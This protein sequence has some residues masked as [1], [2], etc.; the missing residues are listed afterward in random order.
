M[1][2]LLGR[3]LTPPTVSDPSQARVVQQLYYV[4]LLGVPIAFT[5]LIMDEE[6]RAGVARWNDLI[7]GFVGL[8]LGATILILRWGY[9]R[10]AAFMLVISSLGS[11]GLASFYNI[12]IRN[13]SMIA[14]PVILMVCSIMLGSRPTALFATI[15]GSMATFLYFYERS[16]VSYPQ[17]AVADTNYWLVNLLLIGMTAVVLHLTINQ[18]VKSEERN[19]Q[20]AEELQV[21]NQQLARTQLALEARTH[22]LSKLNAELQSEMNERARTEAALRQKQKLESIGLLAGGIAHDFNNLLTSILNQSDMALRRVESDDKARLHLEKAIQSTQRAADLTRQLLAYAGKARFQVEALDLNEL[23]RANSAL[24]ETVLQHNSQLQLALEPNLPAVMSDRGQLQQILMNLVIN[25][26]ESI[27]HEHGEI[28]IQTTATTLTET[29][30]PTTFVG[31]APTAGD[32]V[33]LE[34]CD[35]GSGIDAEVL[36]KI[37]DPFFSTKEQGNGLGLS[38]VLGVVQSLQGSLQVHSTPQVGSAFRVFLPASSVEAILAPPVFPHQFAAAA[39]PLLS[40]QLVLIIDDEEVVRETAE[41]MLASLG[42]RTLSAANGYDGLAVFEQH[43]EQIH[44]VLL[45]VVMPGINGLE[46]L[47]KLRT[48]SDHAPVVLC[49]GYS[50]SAMPDAVLRHPTT[51]FLAKPYTISQLAHLMA[52]LGTQSQNWTI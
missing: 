21:Q 6:V 48:L 9:V 15:M 40:A 23:V 3:L 47:Q 16:G 27:T 8:V 17:P 26:A 14:V 4:L 18:T 32:Y 10:F 33:C 35:N 20:Q 2:T 34:I 51:H 31:S 1:R 11:I 7:G 25:A 36:E 45:D 49:S 43:Q 22:Q 30:D 39:E 13:P 28:R 5:F 44:M 50:N 37:F 38:A 29:L 42:Y 52:M 41:D 19:R 46:T 24:L 12:G